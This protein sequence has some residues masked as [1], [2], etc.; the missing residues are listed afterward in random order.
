MV[1]AADGRHEHVGG[2]CT[3]EGVYFSRDDVVSGIQLGEEWWT[4]NGG[5]RTRLSVAAAC[6]SDGCRTSP[7]LEVALDGVAGY[8]LEDLAPC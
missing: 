5:P 1:Q 6:P 3:A 4:G 8:D 2:V 7:Y